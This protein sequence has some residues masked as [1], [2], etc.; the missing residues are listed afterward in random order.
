MFMKVKLQFF[1]DVA[2]MMSSYLKQF[3]TDNPMMPFV[4]EVLENL[5]CRLRKIFVWK[6]I[7]DEG[8]AAYS[9]IKIDLQKQIIYHRNQS[10]YQLPPKPF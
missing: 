1:V 8:D 2:S 5:I 6:A 7:V 4:S 3:Q 9:L 10:S